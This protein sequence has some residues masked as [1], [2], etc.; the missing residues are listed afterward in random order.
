MR[1]N[2]ETSSVVLKDMLLSH[3]CWRSDAGM[4]ARRPSF[5]RIADIDV[6]N[7][8]L[9]SVGNKCCVPYAPSIRRLLIDSRCTGGA[10]QRPRSQVAGFPGVLDDE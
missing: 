10:Q 5:G 3:Q 1:N 4:V 7:I 8:R 9:V 6:Q 2:M